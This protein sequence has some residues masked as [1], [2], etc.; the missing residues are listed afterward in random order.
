[1]NSANFHTRY[2]RQIILKGFGEEAQQKLADAKVLVVGAGGLGCPA[3]QYLVAAGVGRVGVVD[4]DVVSLSN[5]HRQVLY[6]ADDV[7]QPKALIAAE[8]LRRMNPDVT[9]SPYNIRLKATNAL[10][11]LK[12]YDVVVDGTDNFASRYLINDACVLLGKPLVYGAV[13]QY[14]GQVAVFN[15]ANE[16]GAA[17]HY[18]HLFP[19]PPEHGEVANCAE[20]GVLGVLPGIIGAM[21]A[22][23]VIKLI[24]C[25]GEPLTNRLLTYNA[26]TQETYAL[27]L[28]HH[29]LPDGLMSATPETFLQTDYEAVCG[30]K[31]VGVM[32]IDA[33]EFHRLRQR[34]S[35][36]VIDVRERGEQPSLNGLPHRQ[37]PMSVFEKE[38]SGIKEETVLLVCQHGIRSLHAAELLQEKSINSIKIFSL[39]GGVAKWA[40]ALGI[41]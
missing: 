22:M 11:I 14:E 7:G 15:V 17:V 1:M 8:R 12:E 23:E 18:R 10:D 38:M 26:L 4:D 35:S 41:E 34:P 2:N 13:S 6:T 20:A 33:E 40:D 32:E 28:S 19:E 25:I 9:I 30:T 3:L 16:E 31:P 5:L 37:L 21:Q 36:I 29:A 27:Q 24:T 39:K